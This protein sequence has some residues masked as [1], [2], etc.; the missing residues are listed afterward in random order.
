VLGAH[1]IPVASPAVLPRLAAAFAKVRAGKAA[2]TPDS[3][4]RVIY[5]AD[6]FSFLMRAPRRQ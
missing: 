3:P 1:N 6:G 2:S 5:K 4:G